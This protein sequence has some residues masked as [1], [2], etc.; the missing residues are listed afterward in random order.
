MRDDVGLALAA[1]AAAAEI[2]RV[3]AG[4]LDRLQQALLL[5]D[6][7]GLAADGQRHVERRAGLGC[8]EM[9]EMHGLGRPAQCSGAVAHPVDHAGRAADIEMRAE[10]LRRQQ[11]VELDLLAAIVV[12]EPDAA[13]VALP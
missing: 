6:A 13:V 3:D 5:V 7:D 12:I 10:R 1:D 8:C 2:G 9:L 4:R 11:P